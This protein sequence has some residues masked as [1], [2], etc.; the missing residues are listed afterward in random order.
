VTPPSGSR[1]GETR[2][3]GPLRQPIYRSLW[4]AALVSNLGTWMHEA[5]GAWMM[6]TLASSPL[7]VAL[8]Q[9]AA[10]LPFFML[11]FPAGALADI[12]DRRRLLLWTQT[13]ML[14][15]AA[16]LGVLTLAGLVTPPMLLGLT[17]TLGI[18]SAM[19]GPA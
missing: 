19:T 13:W 5:A 6:T 2:A 18:G 16:A 14:A 9:T 17:F 3:W 7:L 15:S 8:M 1:G 4:L 10:S 12:V 11:A